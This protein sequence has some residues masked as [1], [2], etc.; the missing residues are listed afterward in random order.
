VLCVRSRRYPMNSLSCTVRKS[1]WA[2]L[3]L[4]I[5]RRH[6]GMRSLF[7]CS[8]GCPRW[9]ALNFIIRIFCLVHYKNQS[10]S[11]DTISGHP[12]VPK[13]SNCSALVLKT[14]DNMDTAA[15]VFI[16]A[17]DNRQQNFQHRRKPFVLVA[18]RY[19]LQDRHM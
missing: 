11:H 12:Y 7:A 4:R 6:I 18:P 9:S 15:T 19:L 2:S 14:A 10:I 16:T 13:S 5:S 1:V 17:H 3:L 8:R